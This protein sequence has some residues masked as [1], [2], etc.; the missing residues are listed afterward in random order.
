MSV[1]MGVLNHRLG[2]LPWR[3]ILTPILGLAVSSIGT[4]FIAWFIAQG[5]E[6]IVPTDG[7]WTHVGEMVVAGSLAGLLFIVFIWQLK[8]PE[9]KLLTDRIMSKLKRQK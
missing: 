8:L 7:F 9:M 3:G 4:G 1:L 2:G 5:F 6:R